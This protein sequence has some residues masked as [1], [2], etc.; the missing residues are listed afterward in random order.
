VRY[1]ANPVI[2]E[3]HRIREVRGPILLLENGENVVPSKEMKARYEPKAGDYWVIQADG[4][5]YLNPCDV[6]ERKYS[7]EPVI[8]R[9][10]FETFK[11]A[12]CRGSYV[13][14]SACDACE[15]C[16]WERNQGRAA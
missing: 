12:T 14:G 7:A 10:P 2:V 8:G 15:K 11:R 9:P 1:R 13:L 3:A 6:F 16:A 4:Y 5:T